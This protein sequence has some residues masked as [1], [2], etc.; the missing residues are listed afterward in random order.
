[1]KEKNCNKIQKRLPSICLPAAAAAAALRAG[2][3]R[4]VGNAAEPRVG[5][6]VAALNADAKESIV[7]PMNGKI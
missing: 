2:F 1:M 3:D 7:G 6:G 4:G 5:I